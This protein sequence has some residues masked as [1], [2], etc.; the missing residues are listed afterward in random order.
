MNIACIVEGSGDVKAVP[1][2]VRRIIHEIDPV[3]P[4]TISAPAIRV[5]RSKLV[6]PGEIERA[7]TLAVLKNNGFGGVLVLVDADDDC[8]GTLGPQLLARAKA[9][10]ADMP[11]AV[12]LANHEYEAW[13]LASA[14]SLRGRQGLS[15]TI[16][17][18]INPE[19][20]RGAKEWL[21][22]HMEGSRKYS[23]TIDQLAL[24]RHL[25]MQAARQAASFD[26]LYRD[27]ARLI[28]EL[29]P[30]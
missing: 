3:A 14:A 19:G 1:V 8:P 4:L 2:L 20:V 21:K 30:Q 28:R 13:F 23:E 24:T 15:G 25:D 11:M 16:E 29:R 7:V 22:N 27:L 12:V 17:P 6:K 10:R 18:P 26:K 5:S 9:A